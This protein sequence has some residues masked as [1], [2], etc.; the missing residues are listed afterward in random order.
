MKSREDWVHLLWKVNKERRHD[1]RSEDDKRSGEG[2]SGL[3]PSSDS[4]HG[5]EKENQATPTILK[6]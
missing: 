6:P 4:T 3:S 2:N 5:P 1:K